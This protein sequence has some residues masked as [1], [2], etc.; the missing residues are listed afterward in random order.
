MVPVLVWGTLTQSY[1]MLG[2]GPQPVPP[3]WADS[4]W[5]PWGGAPGGRVGQYSPSPV[6]GSS[7]LADTVLGPDIFSSKENTS[8][9]F[10]SEGKQ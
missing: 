1:A 10:L 3:G 5:G 8:P 2:T 4:R 9:H 6:P 7:C